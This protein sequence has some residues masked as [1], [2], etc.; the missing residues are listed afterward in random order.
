MFHCWVL[1][2]NKQKDRL[3]Q[4][5]NKGFAVLK[6]PLYIDR[7]ISKLHDYEELNMSVSEIRE[8]IVQRDNLLDRIKR[9]E[10]W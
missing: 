10:Q 9:F 3:T 4:L 2:M 7:A 5:N 8:M 1:K 6:N